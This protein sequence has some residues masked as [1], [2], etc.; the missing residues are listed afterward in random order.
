[1]FI[2]DGKG[3][4]MGAYVGAYMGSIIGL[5]KRDTRSL[6]YSSCAEIGVCFADV[7]KCCRSLSTRRMYSRDRSILQGI[8][9]F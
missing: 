7:R 1:M 8:C 2:L 3:S 6:D 9:Q 4:L 5:I